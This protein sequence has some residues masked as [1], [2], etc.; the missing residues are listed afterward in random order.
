MPLDFIKI[1]LPSTLSFLVGILVTPRLTYYFY[2]YKM[3][4]RV[5]RK[6]NF[7]EMSEEWK[8]IHNEKEE[9]STPRVGGIVIWL[10]VFLITAILWVLSRVSSGEIIERFDYV[11]RS[12]TWLPF[13]ALLV[14]GIV[15]LIEDSLEIFTSKTKTLSH[16]LDKRVLIS[17]IVAI[18]LFFGWWFFAKLG[19]STV[20]IPFDGDVNLGILF[21][22]FFILVTLGIFSSR[23]I[24]GIDGLSGGV[25]AIIFASYSLIAFFNNQIDLATFSG[26]VAGA[27]LAFLWFNIPPARFYMGETGMLALALS[28]SIVVFMTGE[29][30]MLILIGLP[31]VITSISSALQIFSKKYFG[32]KVF[33]IAPLHHHFEALGWS[34][35]KI[36]M[37]YWI[38][39]LVCGFLGVII[40]IVS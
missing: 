33:K 2:K 19:V 25:L 29:V 24:D 40:S 30:L 32:K 39:S 16:G 18:G 22:P 21:I 35:P 17:I 6:D 14:G 37:R 8:K 5:S 7:V 36:V 31:L 26:V 34:R 3:W 27:I 4:K 28:L 1:F 12:Q 11:S 38:V 9:V 23:V 13:F 15:G 20:H 10:S